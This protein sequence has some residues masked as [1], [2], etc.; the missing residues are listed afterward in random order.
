M[1]VQYA[2]HI[3][4]L[5]CALNADQC[6]VQCLDRFWS[7]S[8]VCR[9]HWVRGGGGLARHSIPHLTIETIRQ[10]LGTPHLS[11]TDLNF[12]LLVTFDFS[13]YSG[14]EGWLGGIACHSPIWAWTIDR[15][16]TD[17]VEQHGIDS[18]ELERLCRSCI[19]TYIYMY[20]YCNRES[21][22]LVL[23]AGK[24]SLPVTHLFKHRRQ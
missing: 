19:C 18:M 13:P 4:D 1:L 16:W 11:Q 12:N 5:G 14:S 6:V 9:C 20:M 2:K 3:Q 24:G 10:T 22:V 15:H 21:I 7:I 17:C 23:D 8:V